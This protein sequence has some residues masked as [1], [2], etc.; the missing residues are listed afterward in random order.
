MSKQ[1]IEQVQKLIHEKRK[2]GRPKGSFKVEQNELN[3][4]DL[5]FSVNQFL[6]E[7]ILNYKKLKKKPFVQILRQEIKKRYD[8]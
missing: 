5:T 6:H 7:K 1:I 8:L 3:N 2:T 4:I